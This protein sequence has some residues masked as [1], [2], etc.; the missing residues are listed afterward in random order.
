MIRGEKILY[1]AGDV[2]EGF[3]ERRLAAAG[4]DENLPAQPNQLVFDLCG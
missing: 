4:I 3:G 2:K 1:I